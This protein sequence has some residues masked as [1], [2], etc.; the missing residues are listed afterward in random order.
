MVA[1]MNRKNLNRLALL[2]ALLATLSATLSVQP[3]FAL[4]AEG[5]SRASG[6]LGAGVIFGEPTG[7]TGKYWLDRDIAVD[8]GL[9]FSFNEYVL[10]YADYLYHFPG[11]FGL[12]SPITSQ[13]H[14]YVGIGGFLGFAGADRTGENRDRRKLYGD[15]T[16]SVALAL[17]IPVGMEWMPS[18]PRLGV[19]LELV[20]G[21]AL[22]PSTDAIFQGG[23]GVRY[24]F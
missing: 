21:I 3:S 19:F 15:S 11:G 22:V 17:R 20:P 12:E 18:N 16:S 14:P 13:L 1:R 23:I 8:F 5:S 24:Y 10:V 7:V 4:A 6:D 2:G 9:A